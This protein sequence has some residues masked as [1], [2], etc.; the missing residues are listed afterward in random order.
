ML[1]LTHKTLIR[2]SGAFWLFIG[3]LL[4][5]KGLRLLVEGARLPASELSLQPLLGL[6]TPWFGGSEEAA[7]GM[8][9][10]AL[11]VGFFK[12]RYVLA[13]SVQRTASRIRSFAEPT[14][15]SAIYS[16]GYLALIASMVLIG[17]CIRYFQVPSDIRGVIDVAIGSALLNGAGLY[18]RT[19]SRV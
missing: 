17:F 18:F 1:K 6:L 10:A 2:I 12:G 5:N 11:T 15:L 3:A 9:C 8:I 7:I 19:A 4:L 13:K 16:K 14:P